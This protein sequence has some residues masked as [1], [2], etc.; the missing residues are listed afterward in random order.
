MATRAGR[1]ASEQRKAS[2]MHNLNY[3]LISILIFIK[4]LKRKGGEKER[5]RRGEEN[6]LENF[7]YS[8]NFMFN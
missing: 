3:L 5:K 1:L 2:S 6:A 4:E 7:N 8:I